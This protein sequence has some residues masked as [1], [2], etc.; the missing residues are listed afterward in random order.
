M[1]LSL[2]GHSVSVIQKR[3]AEDVKISKVSLYALCKKFRQHGTIANLPRPPSRTKKLNSEQL[4]FIDD[5][6]RE[7]DELTAHQLRE[8]LYIHW[9]GLNVSISTVKRVRRSLGWVTSRPKYCQ[10]V[11]ELNMEK[12][13]LFCQEMLACNERF[14]DVIFT[15]ECSV[16]LDR[17]GRLC[18]RKEGEPRKL[19][20]KP[21][22]PVKVHVWGG[23][24]MCGA[25][26]LVLFTGIM[27]AEKYV[28]ILEH[29]LL[30]FIDEKFANEKYRFQQ[31]NDPKHVS[32]T[33]QNFFEANEINWWKTP[34]ESPDLNPIENVWGYLKYFL[35]NNYKPTNL[36]TLEAGIMQFWEN[37]TPEICT[38][39]ISHIFKVMPKV[40]ECNGAA[41]GF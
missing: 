40:V 20:P 41:S 7:S 37:L 31:D 9:P 24:S 23:I 32:R 1:L 34:P 19:K 38:K 26:P 4:Q 33:A 30:P 28:Q 3:L 27:N 18:F 25:T 12:R 35:R 10:I 16:Q 14:E 2:K 21:K 13:L 36:E 6:L 8:L 29:G 15:D 39:F 5:S 11:R 22:H 17:H